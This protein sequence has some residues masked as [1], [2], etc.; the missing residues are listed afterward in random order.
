MDDLRK[1][2]VGL[3]ET[4]FFIVITI[5]ITNFAVLLF[6]FFPIAFC[7]EHFLV[8]IEGFI[9]LFAPVVREGTA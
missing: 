8:P 1:I 7:D 5:E 4:K 3:F 9:A 6:Y 2:D